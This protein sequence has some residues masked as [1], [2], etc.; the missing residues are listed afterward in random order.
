MNLLDR[1]I[2]WANPGRG[3]ARAIARA[4]IA[5]AAAGTTTLGM[6]AGTGGGH[7]PV[8]RNWRPAPRDANTDTLRWL[9]T[10]RGQSRDLARTHPIAVGAMGTLL[11]RV[12]G[13]GLALV[14]TP[15][16]QA[17]GW[18]DEQAIEWRAA[19]QREFS[20]WA[21][22]AECDL[23][24]AGNFYDRQRLVLESMRESGDCFT[25][26]PD[27]DPAEAS[28]DVPYR[29][30]LQVLEADRIGNPGGL[31]DTAEVAGGVRCSASG[32]PLAYHVYTRHPGAQ[33]FG[34]LGG[35]G[36]PYGGQWIER[37]GATAR[38][39][40]LH[41]WL[42]TRPEQRRGV[43]WLAPIIALLK[44]LDTYTDAEI[45]AAVVSAFFTVFIKSDS[46][47]SP[48]FGDDAAGAAGDEIAM[49]PA[50][51]VGLAKGEDAVFADP[52][53]PNV[54]FDPFVQALLQQVGMALGIPFE[55][56]IK[57]F[58]SSYSASKAALLD[59]W[60]FFRGQRTWLARSFC[61][62]V[63]ETWLSEA[64]ATGR[65]RA[66]GYFSDAL[67]R[68]AYSQAAW[69]GDSQGSINPRDEVAAYIDAVEA[70]LMTHERAEWELFSSDFNDTLQVKAS[71][72]RRLDEA[73]L[74]QQP[75]P[76]A[77]APNAEQAPPQGAQ[78]PQ[79]PQAP[80][81]APR[82]EPPAKG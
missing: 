16:A 14:S 44:D 48:V 38:H 52:K 7:L 77:A 3:A 42:P 20:L 26:L 47:A 62:P 79:A 33:M 1:A 17:L 82:Q 65:V 80:P 51:V 27:A 76:G 32:R 13:T 9:P 41:H 73:G 46:G 63:Y 53:R 58:N 15:N 56:L 11:D 78:A 55:L 66:P 61:Q 54:A 2:A 40:I 59:A 5:M 43:P 23:H 4:R 31:Q 37:R 8:R 6:D 10:Q 22:S 49:G 60:M 19:V 67:L 50:A 71:E 72:R 70:N 12:V 25:L 64:V 74:R 68:W 24:L 28:A 34:G 29:L 18:S 30:R 21:D 35:M 69:I 45:K 39:R 75:R 81:T 57:R 36:N